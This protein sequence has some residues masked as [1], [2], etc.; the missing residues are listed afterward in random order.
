MEFQTR[1]G[2]YRESL[3]QCLGGRLD[4][5]DWVGHVVATESNGAVF[6]S[7]GYAVAGRCVLVIGTGLG[8]WFQSRRVLFSYVAIIQDDIYPV[9]PV[10]TSIVS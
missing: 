5:I 9:V 8:V 4:A 1:Q 2:N 10:G 7:S 6:V 3:A